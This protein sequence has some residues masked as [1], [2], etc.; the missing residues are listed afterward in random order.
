MTLTGVIAKPAPLQTV[1][2]IGVT[3]GFG[4]TVTV[5]VKSDPVQ[6]PDIGVTV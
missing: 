5:T 1:E 2:V 3:D 6:L 4:F